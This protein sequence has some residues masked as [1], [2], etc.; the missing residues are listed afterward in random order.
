MGIGKSEKVALVV[1][2]T[3]ESCFGNGDSR[4]NNVYRTGTRVPYRYDTVFRSSSC[5]Y[6]GYV[7]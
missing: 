4:S 2:E 5:D 3:I 6:V 7:L 1:S